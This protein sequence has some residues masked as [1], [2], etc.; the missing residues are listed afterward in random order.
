MKIIIQ[1]GFFLLTST[2][3]FGQVQFQLEWLES[4]ESYKVSLVSDKTWTAPQNITSTLQV[5]LK[6]PA[7]AFEITDIESLQNEVNFELNGVHESPEEAHDFDYVSIGLTSI[8]TN[9]ISYV[10]GAPVG[11]FTFKNSK[12]CGG[13]IYLVGGEDVFLPP[14]SRNVNIGNQ[15]TV[16][17]AGGQAYIGNVGSGK[18]DCSGFVSSTFEEVSESTFE[19]YPT[20]V[21]EQMNLRLEWTGMSQEMTL[22]VF[23]ADGKKA[24]TRALAVLNGNNTFELEAGNLPTGVYHL[25]MHTK[26]GTAFSGRFVKI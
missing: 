9:G 3:V 5:S 11:L 25:K 10:A 6:V 4:I 7:G 16:L 24:F 19:V 2:T 1:L 26:D 18:A 22:D 15:V 23:D 21:K 13:P 14:N 8:G 17:G 12:P 20:M